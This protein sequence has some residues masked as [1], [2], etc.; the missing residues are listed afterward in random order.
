MKQLDKVHVVIGIK[1]RERNRNST[2]DNA[3][4]IATVLNISDHDAR[5]VMH[6]IENR[7]NGGTDYS[8]SVRMTYRQLGRY[9]AMRQE[10]QL[11]GHWLWPKVT[12]IERPT[13]KLEHIYDITK[14][15]N[16]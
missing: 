4:W 15:Q 10:D 1:Q 12:K 9:V 7:K 3:I 16:S 2:K 14:G 11:I 13:P 5:R 6:D 8:V